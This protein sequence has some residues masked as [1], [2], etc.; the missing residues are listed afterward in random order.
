[1]DLRRARSSLRIPSELDKEERNHYLN[2]KYDSNGR[3][4]FCEYRQSGR[5]GH[6]TSPK[7]RTAGAPLMKA[8][9]TIKGARYTSRGPRTVSRLPPRIRAI[10]GPP[11]GAHLWLVSRCRPVASTGGVASPE[12]RSDPITPEKREQIIAFM[13]AGLMNA[14]EYFRKSGR[15]S[16][17]RC[18]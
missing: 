16:R 7:S 3:L 2:F 10:A 17:R 14:Y 6:S 9:L 5:N 1:M 13:A 18:T 15:R 11:L 8:P 4:L 12:M